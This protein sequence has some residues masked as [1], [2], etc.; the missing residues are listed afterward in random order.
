M[1]SKGKN[2]LG[3][4]LQSCCG[5]PAT[6]FHR[7]GYCRSDPRDLGQHTVC[8]EL[9]AAFLAFTRSRGNDLSTA[10]PEYG[11]PGLAPGDR[12]CL[13]AARWREAWEAGVAPPVILEACDESAL[14]LI[15]LEVLRDHA[16]T[17]LH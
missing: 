11:F 14:A 10:R 17:A 5:E 16:R 6:G 7:D 12:W 1:G 8:A 2:V 4:D 9:T 15:P 3:T 13:C